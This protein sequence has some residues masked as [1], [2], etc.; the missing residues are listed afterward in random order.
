MN[1]I[2]AYHIVWTAY[3]TW[4]SGDERGWVEWGRWEVQAP[5]PETERRH[6]ERMKEPPVFFTDEQCSLVEKTIIDHCRIRGWTLHAVK[7]KATHV[8]VVVT[9]DRKGQEVRDQFKAWCSR[10]LSDAA[11]L[12]GPVAKGAGRRHWFTEGGDCEHIDTEEYLANAIRYVND[13]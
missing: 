7:A 6:R 10:K 12:K 9:A 2:I 5:D 3:G 13:Q 8:H 11:G 4:L 1:D